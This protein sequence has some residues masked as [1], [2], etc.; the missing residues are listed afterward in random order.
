MTEIR[1]RTRERGVLPVKAPS[2]VIGSCQVIADE[3]I[4]VTILGRPAPQG[5]KSPLGM[6]ANPRTRPWREMI[7]TVC[8]KKL[9]DNWE[10]LDG[11]LVLEL[12]FWF[13]PPASAKPG[14][15]PCTKTTYDW[16]KL[17]RAI[18]DGLTE[19]GVIVD[20]AR[21][22]DAHVYK[23][24]IFDKTEARAIAIVSPCRGS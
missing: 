18:G 2:P 6:E 5:S 15:L 4:V 14:D 20:D 16:D 24:Y 23:R 12:W 1:R 11:P 9:P 7:R 3:T 10:K 8:E 22:V 17:S 19:G 21:I 13:D